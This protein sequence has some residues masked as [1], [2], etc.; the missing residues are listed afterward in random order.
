MVKDSVADLHTDRIML[1]AAEIFLEWVQRFDSVAGYLEIPDP[2]IAVIERQRHAMLARGTVG[3]HS[4]DVPFAVDP[5]IVVCR[6][7]IAMMS[8]LIVGVS[9]QRKKFSGLY[10]WP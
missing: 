6:Y 7:E 3:V 4:A 9:A 5:E 1:G 2:P 10:M 8:R